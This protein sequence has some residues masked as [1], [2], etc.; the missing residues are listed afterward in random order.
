MPPG[1][2]DAVQIGGY[3]ARIAASVRPYDPSDRN[4]LRAFQLE[5]F[6]RSSRQAQD[7]Y[8]EWLFE[9]NPHRPAGEAALWVCRRD[10]I[11]VG[12]QARL[13]V[14]LKIGDTERHAS[15]GVDLMVHPD[16]RLKGVGPAL[17]AEYEASSDVLMGLG[18]SESVYGSCVRSGWSDVGR[19]P[20]I[21]RPLDADA[22][23]E[24]LG[25]KRWLARLVPTP[26]LKASARLGAVLPRLAGCSLQR[27][28]TFDE[29][30]ESVWRR[31]RDDYPILVKRDFAA[32]RWRFDES[33]DPERYERYYLMQR[34]QLLGYAVIRFDLWRGHR[35]ARLVD[36][37]C[38]R[39]WQIPLLALVIDAMRG[40]NAVAVFVEQ[41]CPH[42]RDA[43]MALGCFR[44]GA[45]TRFIVK[46]S[47]PASALSAALCQS[48]QW[49]VTPADSDADLIP[50]AQS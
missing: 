8:F 42:R 40:R 32:L 3:A 48:V 15:W 9:R 38:P 31:S 41:L 1:A 18:V 28:D 22:C 17:F 37:L 11:I 6:G 14:V 19:L 50:P 4:A 25:R 34:G 27:I 36:Y 44:V 47:G 46:A 13:P 20:L 24:A 21:A 7:S 29:R 30:V 26:L 43:L 39:R 49:F 16:W 5:H 2:A 35:V 33:P 45:A 10:G 23:A 12:Q